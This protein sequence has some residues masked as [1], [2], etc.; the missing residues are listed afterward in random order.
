MEEMWLEYRKTGGHHLE[1]L[2]I[3]GIEVGRM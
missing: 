1:D 2:D 3:G